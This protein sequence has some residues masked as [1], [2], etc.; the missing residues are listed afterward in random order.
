MSCL[1]SFGQA[2]IKIGII[3]LD[4]S[5]AIAFTK[6]LNGKDRKEEFKDFSI[7]AAYPYG[8]KTIKSSY[9]RIPEYIEQVKKLGVEI[10]PSISELL[11]KVDCVLL[12]TND[13]NPHLEQAYE[14]IKSR[15]KLFIDKPVGA[16]LAQAIAI[17]EIA[18]K[19][20]VPIFSSSAL[21]FSSQNQ[22]LR[23]GELGKVIGADMYT[24]GHIEP[25]HSDLAW[26]GIHG[27]EPLFT[28]M[29]TGCVSVNSTSSQGA[30]VTT[31]LW[32]DGRIGTVRGIRDGTMDY[33]GLAFTD[34]TIV[35]S[36]SYEG[37]ETLLLEI[38][39]F[40]KT[41]ISPVSPKETLEIFTF[42][43]ASDLSKKK[44]GNTILLEDA[45]NKSFKKAKK[46]IKNL[47]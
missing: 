5:H 41:G 20:K 39:D 44:D 13:G 8:S 46:M 4:T 31:G 36:G 35:H 21:R 18:K 26:Y 30:T 2:Q 28:I 23:N 10:V 38:L 24:P 14:V 43:E 17:Y 42:I 27:V 12:E 40:F 19:Y 25:T 33:G 16:N 6:F 45:Y 22:K 11:V 37:Y 1:I 47:K 9:D 34:K 3:G 29:G 32:D 15:K 7:V